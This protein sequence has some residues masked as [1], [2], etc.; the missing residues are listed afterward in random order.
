MTS[1]FSAGHTATEPF[2]FDAETG[3]DRLVSV[4]IPVRD[5][6]E[7]L[8][9]LLALLERQT[10]PRNRFEIVIGD[11]GSPPH[12]LDEVSTDDGWIRVSSDAPRNS[13]AARN[14]AAAASRGEILAFCDSDCQPERTWLEEGLAALADADVVAGNVVFIAPRRPTTWTILTVD[15]FLDQERNVLLSR[16]VTANLFVRREAFDAVGHFDDTLPSGGDYDFV[17]RIVEG[18]GELVYAPGAIVRHPTLDSMKDFLR[19]VWMTNKWSALRRVRSGAPPDVVAVLTSFVPVLGVAW[20]RRKA[21][22]S[23]FTL[24]QS[25]LEAAG[26]VLD[27]M[28]TTIALT[29]LHLVVA[30]VAGVAQVVG[31][32]QGRKMR[33]SSGQKSQPS[34]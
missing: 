30:Y 19:K 18:R 27:G 9:T 25:R 12:S 2:L 20:A 32:A 11:D 26:L 15:M 34:P 24:H 23:A 29:A 8:R 6:V 22:R 16:G 5:D 17:N 13:Y 14:R 1:I 7:R 10:L 33:R 4:I 31:W 28:Q 21:L 3:S